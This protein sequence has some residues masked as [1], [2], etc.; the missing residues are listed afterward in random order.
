MGIDFNKLVKRTDKN[1]IDP[2][3]IFDV[4]PGKHEKYDGYLRDVQSEV[5]KEWFL[6]G[7]D[8]KDSIIKMNTGSGKTVVGLL[9]LQSYINEGYGP[10][11]YVVPDNYLLEQVKLEAQ[12]LNIKY[13][14]E[15]SDINFLS[16]KS[17]L[18]INMHKLFNGSSVFGVDEK[19][20][21][22]HAL[23]VDDA[24]SCIDISMEQSTLTIQNSQPE[25]GL[26]FNIMKDAIRN[27]SESTLIE[28]ESGSPTAYQ[29]IPFWTWSANVSQILPIIYAMCNR[30]GTPSEKEAYFKWPI[31]KDYLSLADVFVS[32]KEIA[33]TLPYVPIEKIPAFTE[34]NHR[35]FMSA[36]INDDTKII[37]HLGVSSDYVMISPKKANDIGERLILSPQSKDARITDTIMK[38]LIQWHSKTVNTVVL[39]PSYNRAEFWEDVADVVIRSGVT[40]HETIGKMKDGHVGLVVI[41]N[42]YDGID[43]PKAACEI[44]V[45]DSLPDYRTLKE[46]YEQSVLRGTTESDARNIRIIEQGMGRAVRSK[47]D[48][49]VIYLMNSGLI[50]Q[51]YIN[52]S[53]QHFSESTR[54]QLELSELVQN[55]IEGNNYREAIEA[56]LSRD[57]SWISASKEYIADI[58]YIHEKKI[59]KDKLE[60]K[61]A[62]YLACNGNYQDAAHKLQN[63]INRNDN[64][65]KKGYFKFKL[66][67]ITNF[68]SKE[69]AQQI[70]KSANKLNNQLSRPITGIEYNPVNINK[71]SQSHRLREF[72]GN[73]YSN[74]NDF[75][76]AVNDIID[77]LKFQSVSSDIFEEAIKELGYHLGMISQRPEK[78]YA[79]GPDNLWMTFDNNNFV[80]ECKNEA[81]VPTI[82]KKYCNQLNGSIEWFKNSYDPSLQLVPIM[83]HPSVCFEKAA[84]PN[85]HIRV[86]DEERLNLLKQQ[87]KSFCEEIGES[88]FDIKSIEK[89]LHTHKLDTK[90]FPFVFTS[91]FR[92]N[93]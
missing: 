26:I 51:L 14:T 30:E 5:L 39:V 24:H 53:R 63:L 72:I 80:I 16:G 20:I 28:I 8:K 71:L 18:I 92:T 58:E 34:A 66:A 31:I 82:T 19:R 64:T 40:L 43:L 27:Q 69:K 90:N 77:N 36:T 25:Y 45:I 57:P 42:R 76:I 70:V 2:T 61:E 11:V 21:P 88:E 68:V 6:K 55:E 33:I 75:L 7:R 74:K 29:S 54:K 89:S 85:K 15:T 83:V 62:Y 13:A 87:F 23:I 52:N 4:L 49:C 56:V 73:K 67:K 46:K 65:R 93:K 9:I 86:I 37:E 48:Y 3:K 60:E 91:D 12:H 81:T 1:V 79:K 41:I 22:I 10:C 17:I 84:S 50:K 47:D 44:L 32:S 38:K 35:L 78:E 59:S